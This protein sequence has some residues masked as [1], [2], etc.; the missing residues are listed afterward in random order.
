MSPRAHGTRGGARRTEETAA[1]PLLP[2][3]T[4]GGPTPLVAAGAPHGTHPDAA[5]PRGGFNSLAR[6]RPGP[7]VGAHVN[8]REI[9]GGG[10]PPLPGPD[11]AAAEPAARAATT[12][13]KWR[14]RIVA[15]GEASPAELVA[16]PG[17]WRSHPPA[18]R[19]ALAGLLDQVGW[20][21]DVVV[22]RRTGRLVDGH[23]RV[24]LA[25]TRGETSVPVLFVDLAEDEE[26]LVLASLDPLAAMAGTDPEKLAAL[27]GEARANDEALRAMLAE[28]ATRAGIAPTLTAGLTDPDDA[29]ALPLTPRTQPGDLYVLGEH[30]L[31]CGDSTRE[32]D[33][34]RLLGAEA[35]R[36][37]LTDPP[38]GVSLELEWRDRA[39][40]AGPGPEERKSPRRREGHTNTAIAGDTRADWSAAFELVASLDTA[41][42]WHASAHAL[43]V[44]MGLRRIGFELKQ[45]IIWRKPH[46]ALS[47]QHYHWQHEPCWYARK[48]KALPFRGRRDQ[49]TIWDA[50]SPKMLM[51]G[52]KEEKV[53]HPTQK[54]AALYV[55]PLQNHLARGAVFYEP[56]AG[57]GTAL[58]AA[59][60]TERRCLAL[61][62]DPRYCDVIVARWEAFTGRPARRETSEVSRG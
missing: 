11:A 56:F 25:R 52:S 4:D 17:N 9:R 61:E 49:S 60:Q 18:Q 40:H 41:F 3:A 62:L 32:A 13:A 58:V 19:K 29:P 23:L 54:P 26:A 51:S 45:Q 38:Y 47:R 21:Q 5:T 50:A 2:A 12:P 39:G 7:R 35:P 16:N 8:A 53:D 34:R 22:N 15:R 42:V 55:R 43:E 28:L 24:E 33:V 57:S 46:F 6:S 31:L 37:L 27:L 14:S 59:E 10:G 1:P 48:L 44:G 20:V 36:L 30:R